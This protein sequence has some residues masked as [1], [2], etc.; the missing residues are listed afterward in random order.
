MVTY[1]VAIDCDDAAIGLKKVIVKHLK[2]N[3]VDVTDLNYSGGKET[4]FYP[5]IGY[6]L[7]KQVQQ[8][9]Y[10]RGI[11]ICGTGLG[12][13]MVANKVEGVFAGTCH[14]VFSAE[15]LKKSNDAQV[16][17]MGARVI[18]AGAVSCCL[19]LETMAETIKGM[20]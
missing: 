15:R 13:A 4:A 1:K 10:D 9:A 7:A 3:G 16:I 17:T 19:I 18:D 5:E 20:L 12:I 6:S 14:D 11:L 8:G 2:D